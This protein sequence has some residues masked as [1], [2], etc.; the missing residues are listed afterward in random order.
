VKFLLSPIGLILIV[1]VLVI[2]FFPRRT[3]DAVKKRMGKPMR[4]FPDDD[5]SPAA[6]AHGTTSTREDGTADRESGPPNASGG[7]K[8]A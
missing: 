3:P 6:D 1:A 2:L 7:R 5:P 4:A 8:G